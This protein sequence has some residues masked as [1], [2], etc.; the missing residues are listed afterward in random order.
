M[1]LLGILN[2]GSHTCKT[3]LAYESI[4]PAFRD[5]IVASI[6]LCKMKIISFSF[7]QETS[8]NTTNVTFYIRHGQCNGQKI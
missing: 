8:M 2:L 7:N 5:R 3:K 6:K 1:Y 4:L